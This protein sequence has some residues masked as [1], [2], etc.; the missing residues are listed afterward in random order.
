ML[1]VLYILEALRHNY[2]MPGFLPGW[3]RKDMEQLPFFLRVEVLNV[4]F[5]EALMILADF[6][7]R[8][9]G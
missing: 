2:I 4:V 7:V 8:K 5:L 1:N 3:T 9:N 6:A